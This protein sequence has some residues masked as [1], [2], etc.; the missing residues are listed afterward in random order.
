MNNNQ[1]YWQRSSEIVGPA[2]A[3]D[4]DKIGQQETRVALENFIISKTTENSK[5]LD[6]GCNTGVEGFRLFQRGYLGEYVGVDSN[7]MALTHAMENLSGRQAMFILS[8]LGGVPLKSKNFDLVFTKDVIEH[9]AGYMPILKD[10]GRMAN[11]YLVISFFIKMHDGP[12]LIRRHP[13]GYFLNR[14][15]R[16]QLIG[17]IQQLGFNSGTTIFEQAED[18]VIVFERVSN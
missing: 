1:T 10:L 11:R 16:A 2:R 17:Y 15:S 4:F 13:E 3:A 8:D 6:G 12:D 9:S 18:E 14:Y 7:P 5:I